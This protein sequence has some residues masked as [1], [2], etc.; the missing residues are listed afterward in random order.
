[1][2]QRFIHNVGKSTFSLS[3]QAQ[4]NDNWVSR[5]LQSTDGSCVNCQLQDQDT[6]DSPCE[7][8]VMSQWSMYLDEPIK[9]GL[10]SVC[11]NDHRRLNVS[12]KMAGCCGKRSGFYCNA[13]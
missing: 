12:D 7:F 10:D 4:E 8:V 11:V 13:L 6:P 5:P 2:P 1:L 3:V 9:G